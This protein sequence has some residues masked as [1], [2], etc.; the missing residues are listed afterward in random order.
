MKF[1]RLVILLVAILLLAI[2]QYFF[3]PGWYRESG[4]KASGW[5]IMLSVAAAIALSV[6]LIRRVIQ[7]LTITASRGSRIGSYLGGYGVYPFALFLGFVVGGN[8]GGG[9]GDNAFGDAGTVVGIGVGVFIVTIFACS[10]GALLGYLLG[11]LTQRL[12]R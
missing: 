4:I 1:K 3:L 11:G 6:W 5:L 9:I 8:F 10:V 12:V 7:K 2:A